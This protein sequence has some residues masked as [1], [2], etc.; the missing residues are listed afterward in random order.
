MS[1]NYAPQQPG[2]YPYAA[3]QPPP[4]QYPPTQPGQVPLQPGQY[5]PPQPGQYPPPQQYPPP[6][7]YYQVLAII[8]VIHEHLL[9]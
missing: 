8:T 3:Q 7:A 6:A 5:P 2:Y 4:G 9:L 1:Q